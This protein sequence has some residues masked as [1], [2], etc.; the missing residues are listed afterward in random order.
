MM[1]RKS[2]I[3]ESSPSLNLD[4]RPVPL[5]LPAGAA[6]FALHGRIWLT[7]ERMRD[8]IVLAPGD[9]FDVKSSA[10]ILVSAVK[11]GAT[12]V[13]APPAAARAHAQRDV[14]DFARASALRLRRE[15]S[16][17]LA[18]LARAAAVSLLGRVRAALLARRPAVGH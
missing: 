10:L 13:V 1:N 18:G 15:E 6:V 11:D 12:L 7:Q 8:D 5:R 17:R 4:A 9:R 16:L 3:P 14:Y 2:E